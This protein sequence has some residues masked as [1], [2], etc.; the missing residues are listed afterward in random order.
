[1]TAGGLV[2]D[3]VE[4]PAGVG[5]FDAMASVVDDPPQLAGAVEPV[6]R[7]L[8]SSRSY[9]NPVAGESRVHW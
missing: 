4:L 3:F 1:M 5:E 8:A 6:D 7:S 2:A 9:S